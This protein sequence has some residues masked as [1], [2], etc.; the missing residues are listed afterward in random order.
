[1]T[2]AGRMMA[3]LR[4]NATGSGSIGRMTFRDNS[5]DG[6]R[7]LAIDDY[8]LPVLTNDV[9]LQSGNVLTNGVNWMENSG[10]TTGWRTDTTPMADSLSS[11]GT[12]AAATTQTFILASSC[13]N[14]TF[15]LPNGV[16]D[17]QIRDIE[18]HAT[19]TT[20]GALALAIGDGSSIS[21]IVTNLAPTAFVQLAWDAT[22]TEWWVVNKNN[23]TVNP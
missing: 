12:L 14:D 15:T 1:V 6:A 3:G 20:T 18:V 4:L 5:V 11:S 2:P 17:G 19:C 8:T 16:Y 21:W 7:A 10:F 22:A 23:V 9:P 13:G